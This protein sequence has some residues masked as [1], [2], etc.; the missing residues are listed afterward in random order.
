MESNRR[1][2]CRNFETQ[3][4]ECIGLVFK[5]EKLSFASFIHRTNL[6]MNF[7]DIT[8]VGD[9]FVVQRKREREHTTMTKN[10]PQNLLEIQFS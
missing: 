10:V 9:T 6:F 5:T 8:N 4:N 2:K 7:V 3:T 1:V